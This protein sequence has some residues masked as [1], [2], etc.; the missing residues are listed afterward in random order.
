[1]ATY[2]GGSG[3]LLDRV[4]NMTREEQ[5][6]VDTY[7][8]VLHNPKD[9]SLYEDVEDPNPARIMVIT[10]DLDDWHQRIQ[11]TCRIFTSHRTR[12][13]VTVHITHLAYTH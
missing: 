5:P 9:T 12:A 6:V 11:A 2:H 7:I 3:Q 8:E 13:T 1:M 10:R 4:T